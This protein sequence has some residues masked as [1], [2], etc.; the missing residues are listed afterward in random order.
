MICEWEAAPKQSGSLPY[1]HSIFTCA[2]CFCKNKF[3]SLFR[4]AIV[5]LFLLICLIIGISCSKTETEPVNPS[6]IEFL[7]VNVGTQMLSLTQENKGLP[8][9]QGIMVRFKASVDTTTVRQS[10]RLLDKNSTAVSCRISYLD[11]NS[12]VS[13]MP[14]AALSENSA[15]TLTISNTLNGKQ[16]E[17]FSGLSVSFKT[18][19]PALTVGTFTIDSKPYYPNVRTSDISVLPEIRLVFSDA[20][21]LTELSSKITISQGGISRKLLLSPS[22]DRKTYVVKTES[23]LKGLMKVN[24]EISSSLVSENGH[25]YEGVSGS[26]YTG[27]DP[28]PV[29]PVISDEELLT[30][31]QKQTF[32][33]FWDFA[34]P[35]SGLA[36]ERNTSGEIVTSGGSGFGLMALIVGMDRGFI[37]RDE[38]VARLKKIV[39]FLASADRFHGAWPHWMNGTTGKVYPFSTKD[40]GGDLV[41]TSYLAAGLLT[42]R[43]YLKASVLSEKYVIDRINELCNAIEWDWYTKAN[44]SVLYWHWSPDYG[45]EMNMPIQGYNEALITYVMAASS[46]AHAIGLSAYEQ[47]WA[48]NGTIKNGKTFYGYKLP[49]GSDYGGPLFFAHYSFLGLNPQG[50]SDQYASYW[51]QNVNHTLINRAYC[52]A[53]PNN[54]VNYN[55]VCWGLT[56]SDNDKGYSA[57][58]PT[59]DLGIISPT[60]AISSMPYAPKESMDA[61]KFFYYNLGDRMWGEYGFYDA[62]NLTE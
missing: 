25:P 23:K 19:L 24:F 45:W 42:V 43:Q 7:S 29:F 52:A 59:N 18:L 38:G 5:A 17:S 14:T 35:V 9:D 61:L 13:M 8:T 12:T 53:N 46:S 28:T 58:S 55:A 31:V 27:V 51:E 36:R 2:E 47:G 21:S 54:F 60:A 57:H 40:N 62:M 34:H 11:N 39:D 26:F 44:S 33:Y 30:L 10:I 20:V 16:K 32:R 49:L 41:E 3:M 50:L 4:N 15:Y 1:Y 37:T 22:S 6:A 48:K 56:A